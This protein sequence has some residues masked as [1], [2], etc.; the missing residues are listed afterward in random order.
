MILQKE[1]RISKPQ[2]FDVTLD[3][4]RRVTSICNSKETKKHHLEEFCNRSNTC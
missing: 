3:G 4:R 1:N 2:K